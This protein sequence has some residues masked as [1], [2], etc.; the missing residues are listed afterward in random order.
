MLKL[1]SLEKWVIVAFANKK[2]L[3]MTMNYI[4]SLERT[5]HNKFVM[6]CV[7]VMSYT[8]L[9]ELGYFDRVGLVPRDWLD[10]RG[11][12]DMALGKWMILVELLNRKHSVCFNDVN[13]VYLNNHA[14]DYVGQE[15]SGVNADLWFMFDENKDFFS[16]LISEPWFG[17]T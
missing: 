7:D 3:E 2:T 17:P 13:L 16:E 14:V 4:A 8:V 6:I 9:S 11:L 15:D 5:G 1:N 12:N 10:T